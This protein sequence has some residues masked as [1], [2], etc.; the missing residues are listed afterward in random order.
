[1]ILSGLSYAVI[2]VDAGYLLASSVTKV[3]GTSLRD[4]REGR[5]AR[6]GA[7]R[8]PSCGDD[9][10]GRVLRIYWYDGARGG[11]PTDEQRQIGLLPRTKIRIGRLSYAGEQKGVDLAWGCT[12]S[13]RA[14]PDSGHR[15]PGLGR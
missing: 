2:Y 15:V 6:P 9:C 12:W 5:P 8:D 13:Q 7:R 14:T 10:G 3:L 1:M 4:A 11:A